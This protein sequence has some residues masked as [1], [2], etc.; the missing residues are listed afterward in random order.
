[1]HSVATIQDL[2]YGSSSSYL[3][4]A[5]GDGAAGMSDRNSNATTGIGAGASSNGVSGGGS[6][7]EKVGICIY[8]EDSADDDDTK[9]HPPS[10]QDR[11]VGSDAMTRSY[12]ILDGAMDPIAAANAGLPIA[13]PPPVAPV[14]ARSFVPL[15]RVPSAPG[16]LKKIAL[17]LLATIDMLYRLLPIQAFIELKRLI[18]TNLLATVGEQLLPPAI[19]A[20]LE[21]R[22]NMNVP[23]TTLHYRD[24]N[25][26]ATKRE[27]GLS[28][29]FK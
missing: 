6:K 19:H 22:S 11:H 2:L 18:E 7:L 14:P 5:S 24:H 25:T 27:S 20:L 1:M 17:R 28:T 10:L 23:A 29:K 13:P 16:S 8:L 3:G 12:T 26:A 15:S 4:P 21:E 9:H